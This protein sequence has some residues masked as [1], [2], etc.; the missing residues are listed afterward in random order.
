MKEVRISPGERFVLCYNPEAA[1]RDAA[2]R[3]RLLARLAAVIEGS[4]R[5]SAT[6]RAVLRGAQLRFIR[7]QS[8]LLLDYWVHQL[9]NPGT[10][11]QMNRSLASGPS[12]PSLALSNGGRPR[13][14]TST[15]SV[16]P[17]NTGR[18]ST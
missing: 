16:L 4:D 14:P 1:E 7:A 9:R 6:K 8:P 3:T 12:V 15:W 5:L 10:S 13:I 17:A 2:V 18:L 11:P